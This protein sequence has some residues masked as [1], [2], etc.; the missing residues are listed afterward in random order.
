MSSGPLGTAHAAAQ[1]FKQAFVGNPAK[2]MVNGHWFTGSQSCTCKSG[3]GGIH[4]SGL[5]WHDPDF[6]SDEE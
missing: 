4:C 2:T 6:A 3:N 5:G 1:E